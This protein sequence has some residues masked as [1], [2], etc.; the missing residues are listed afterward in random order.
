MTNK[1]NNAGGS[2][3]A[4]GA[5]FQARV[6]A[7]YCARILLQTPAIGQGFDL[8]ATSIAERIY[9]ETKDSIDDLRVELTGN[10]KIYGQC[11]RSISLSKNTNSDWASVLI[12]FYKE[13]EKTMVT[14]R[15][16]RFVLFYE[17]NNSNLDKLSNFLKRYRQLPHGSA[18]INAA[19]NEPEEDLANNL[20]TLL[21]DLHSKD[22]KTNN[23][24]LQNL[25]N[26]KEL[27]LRHTYIKQ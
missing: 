11:K 26:K 1:S 25:V 6:S 14:G 24:K 4:G 16:R 27:L 2:A 17:E 21:Q 18:L 15:E 9:C 7:W 13:L 23:P 12:Q 5:R 10:D 8:P 20:E 19:H 3:M 22:A